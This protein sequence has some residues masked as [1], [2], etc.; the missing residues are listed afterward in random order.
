MQHQKELEDEFER[1]Q[2]SLYRKTIDLEPGHHKE[3]WDVMGPM[4]VPLA[5]SL[6]KI[7]H[8]DSAGLR[9]GTGPVPGAK[10]SKSSLTSGGDGLVDSDPKSKISFGGGGG[11]DYQAYGKGFHD[12]DE[13]SK[14]VSAIA[15]PP[16]IDEYDLLESD[17]EQLASERERAAAATQKA[18]AASTPSATPTPSSAGSR[19]RAS[20]VAPSDDVDAQKKQARLYG[21]RGF[22]NKIMRSGR[23]DG[24]R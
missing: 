4:V 3:K 22:L 12:P 1:Q 18:R 10:A 13:K 24:S 2:P 9:T 21:G 5:R 17:E 11:S 23:S 8:H 19:E 14:Q 6:A 7:S 15:T 20:S 16:G